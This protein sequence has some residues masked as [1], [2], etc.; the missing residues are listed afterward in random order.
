M[1]GKEFWPQGN[2]FEALGTGLKV[3]LIIQKI[4]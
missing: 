3:Q 2:E 4:P 1:K